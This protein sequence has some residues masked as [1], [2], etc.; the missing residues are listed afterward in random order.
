MTFVGLILK[1]TRFF[2]G[3]HIFGLDRT[4]SVRIKRFRFVLVQKYYPPSRRHIKRSFIATVKQ[5]IVFLEGITHV[6]RLSA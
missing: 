4:V 2:A 3:S 1:T 5:K 6:A